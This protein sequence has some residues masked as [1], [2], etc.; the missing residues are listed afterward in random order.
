M[1]YSR[2]PRGDR[3]A[4]QLEDACVRFVTS[5]DIRAVSADWIGGFEELVRHV[6]STD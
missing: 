3:E 5:H 1:L 4:R 6:A 2:A